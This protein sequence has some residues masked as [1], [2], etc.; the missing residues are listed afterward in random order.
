M[1]AKLAGPGAGSKFNVE[2]NAEINVT[3]FVT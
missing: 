3:P 2:Q 1:G